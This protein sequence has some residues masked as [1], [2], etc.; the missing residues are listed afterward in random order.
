MIPYSGAV[1]YLAEAVTSAVTQRF[2]EIIIINDGCPPEQLGPVAGLAGV[3]VIH[4][5]K[6]IGRSGT[7][8]LGLKTCTT[9]YAV[10]L[11]QDDLL[12]EGYL[13]AISAWVTE[14]RLRCAAAT[15]RYIGKN[16][17]RI[18]ML[19][20][21]H[22]DFFLP[23]GFFSELS[24]I[25]EVGYFMDCYSEDVLFFQAVRNVTSLTT[26]PGARVLYRIHPQAESSRHTRAWWAFNQMLPCYYK[27]SHSLSEI[28]AIARE[29]ESHGTIPAG[30]EAMLRGEEA[31]ATRFLARSAYACW[32]N[33]DLPG[34]ARYGVRLVRYLPSLV[35]LAR[36]KWS[37][38]VP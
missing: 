35:R 17:S 23:S 34:L 15:L 6:S 10:L 12:C 22:R 36:R 26:C 14:R 25:A 8:N 4:L 27:G 38:T 19:V 7:R 16:A 28:N 9:P 3:R 29:Y 31:V 1:K 21:R 37:T 24:L 33:R 18:G 32:L 20:G 13:A 11:D 2:C 5:P 30:M